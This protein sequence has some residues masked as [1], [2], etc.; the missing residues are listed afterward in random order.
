[1]ADKSRFIAGD[2]SEP[3]EERAGMSSFAVMKHRRGEND[4]SGKSHCP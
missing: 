3:A 2:A 4:E 1:M